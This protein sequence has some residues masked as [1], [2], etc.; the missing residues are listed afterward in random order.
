M[1]RLCSRDTNAA[2][3]IAL[4]FLLFA[5]FGRLSIKDC[6][7]AVTIKAKTETMVLGKLRD[8]LFAP[9]SVLRP[10][11]AEFIFVNSAV[12]RG[13]QLLLDLSYELPHCS[14]PLRLIHVATLIR[15]TS[16]NR[17]YYNTVVNFRRTRLLRRHT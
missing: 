4:N 7:Q 17:L 5:S 3:K 11:A 14:P 8:L 6:A 15:I 2:F 9:F 16:V 1:I 12:L 10:D 13:L